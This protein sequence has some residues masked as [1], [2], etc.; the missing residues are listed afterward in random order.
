MDAQLWFL[1]TIQWTTT[2]GRMN[3]HTH[4]ETIPVDGSRTKKQLYELV[5][6][7]TCKA[8]GAPPERTAVL[9]YNI[10][11]DRIPTV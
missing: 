2:Q 9:F 3:F 7:R 8:A 11:M 1:V 4:S 5:Y 10:E 6:A